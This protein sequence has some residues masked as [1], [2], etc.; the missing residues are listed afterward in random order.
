M[1]RRSRRPRSAP[2][3]RS[4]GQEQRRAPSTMP[5]GHGRPGDLGERF[6]V[7]VTRWSYSA[8]RNGN[9]TNAMPRYSAAGAVTIAAS[10]SLRS[11]DQS[12][13][14]VAFPTDTAGS[15]LLGS[16]RRALRVH[17]SVRSETSDMVGSPA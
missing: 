1:S 11:A 7:A 3:R 2:N 10:S 9:S 13:V 12:P 15:S 8:K 16:S 5:N 14:T 17:G 6:G 4:R